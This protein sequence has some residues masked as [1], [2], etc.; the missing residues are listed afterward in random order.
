MNYTTLKNF[1]DFSPEVY[2]LLKQEQNKLNKVLRP[3]SGF[4][5]PIQGSARGGLLSAADAN[6]V[7]DLPLFT[8]VG[9]RSLPA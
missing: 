4:R 3:E 6:L 8:L 5:I 2:R 1:S 7:V 9:E